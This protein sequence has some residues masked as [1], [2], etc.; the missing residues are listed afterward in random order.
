MKLSYFL[1]T[2]LVTYLL[3][4]V[5]LQAQPAT[6]PKKFS[7][8]EAKQYALDNSPVLLNSSRDVEI[9]KKK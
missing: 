7:L 8:N 2:A 1:F 5:R 6:N 3:L 9:A 4:P